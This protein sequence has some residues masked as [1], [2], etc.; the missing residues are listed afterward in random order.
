[1]LRLGGLLLLFLGL[2][3]ILPALLA[4][5]IVNI[6]ILCSL[7]IP[8]LALA[9]L[10][11]FESPDTQAAIYHL[12]IMLFVSGITSMVAGLALLLSHRAWAPRRT[13]P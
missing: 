11:Y 12:R 3:L 2:L 5:F 8:F 6:I 4:D 9:V 7:A 1:M 13:G 10:P